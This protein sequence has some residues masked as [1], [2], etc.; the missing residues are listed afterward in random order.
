MRCLQ[1]ILKMLKMQTKIQYSQ[2]LYL[3]M[4]KKDAY[5]P[6]QFKKSVIYLFFR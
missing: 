5:G 1:C 2:I 4:T 6:L 3:K